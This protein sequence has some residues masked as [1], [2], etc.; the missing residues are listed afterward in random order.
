MGWPQFLRLLNHSSVAHR[1]SEDAPRTR[2]PRRTIRRSRV[3]PH[4]S[5]GPAGLRFRRSP[6]GDHRSGLTRL[7][8]RSPV[9]VAD[10]SVAVELPRESGGPFEVAVNTV[11]APIPLTP[12]E[13]CGLG[14]SPLLTAPVG[15]RS[16]ERTSV[17]RLQKA[18]SRG[19]SKNTGLSPKLSRYP[20]DFF[21]RPRVAHR[22]CT[23]TCTGSSAFLAR[24]VESVSCSGFNRVR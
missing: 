3:S 16:P 18:W 10:S 13:R 1:P 7:P 11:H 17:N 6:E 12:R 24:P 19:I 21:R 20:Q 14:R 23:T 5:N 15:V 2:S 22:S 8:L 9:A 4:P